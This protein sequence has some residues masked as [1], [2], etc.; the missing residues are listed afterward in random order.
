M[1]YVL[2]DDPAIRPNLLPFTSTR[3]VAEIRVGIFTIAEKW[4]KYL[5]SKISYKTQPYLQEKYP[6]QEGK[7]TVYI[8]GAVCPD[9]DLIKAIINLEKGQALVNNDTVLAY[10]EG[11]DPDEIEFK[12]NPCVIRQNWDIFQQNGNQIRADFNLINIHSSEGIKDIH[13]RTY[14]ESDIFIAPNVK[15]RAAVLNAEDGPI[16]LGPGSEVQ[17]GAVIRGP[18]A[19][20]EGSVVN[21]GAKMRG[22]TTIGPYS[23]VGGEVSNSVIFGYSNKGH[24]GFIG[25]TVIGEWCNLG[26]DTNTSN[27]KNNYG[28]VSVYSMKIGTMVETGL[29]FCGMMMGDHSKTSINTMINTGTVVGVMANIFG[30]GFPPKYIPSFAWGGSDGIEEFDFSKAM[31][32]AERVMARRKRKLTEADKNILKHLFEASKTSFAR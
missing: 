32:V 16:Y 4:Q 20:G 1:N 5:N 6:L 14:N 15:I 13:T 12:G 29:Q 7:S 18:F 21:M 10:G 3:P 11:E 23:K 17:E 27:L 24:D 28:N 2:F 9:E 19:L 31:E 25:N 26:A 8:N 22:D 30:S